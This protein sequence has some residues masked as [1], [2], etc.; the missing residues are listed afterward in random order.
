MY[1]DDDLKASG[2]GS[3]QC[4]VGTEEYKWDGWVEC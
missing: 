1:D 3:E 4:V 2:K